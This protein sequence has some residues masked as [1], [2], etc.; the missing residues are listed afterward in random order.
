MAFNFPEGA[1]FQY[2]VT[3]ASP[4][5]ISAV[6]NAN[7]AVLTSTSH[8]YSDNDEFLFLSGWSD[9]NNT[10]FRANQLTADTFEALGLDSSNTTYF[11][12]GTGTGT[13]SK[14]SG[15][16]EIPQVLTIATSGGD[17]KYTD[18]QLLAARQSIKIPTG[19]NAATT[20]LS[21]AHDPANATYQAML[22]ISRAFT[23]CAFRIVGGGGTTYGYGYMTV[24]EAPKMQAGQ[25]NQV[26]C[27]ITMIGRQIAY[28]S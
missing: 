9:A 15:W 5:T 10:V 13:T 18:V 3:F 11:G 17:T 8:G 19:F 7:P 2:S 14:I 20:T 27:A 25:V 21:L 16:T 22:G 24:N 26:D 1:T 4:K 28:A 12:A 6:T 23:L